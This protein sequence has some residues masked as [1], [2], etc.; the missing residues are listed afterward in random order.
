MDTA[1]GDKP[2]TIIIDAGEIYYLRA[3]FQPG[4]VG[5]WRLSAILPEQVLEE[6]KSVRSM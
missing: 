5:L 6:L 1:G 4:L 2:V 3:D